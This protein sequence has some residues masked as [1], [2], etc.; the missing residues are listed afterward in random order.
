MTIDILKAKA[1]QFGDQLG[2]FAPASPV[3]SEYVR[4]GQDYL[5]QSGFQNREG[6]SL[7]CRSYHVAGEPRSRL[8]DFEN[9]LVDPEI[10]GLVAARGG[11]GCLQLLPFLDFDLIGRYPK[12][13]LGFSD[14][15]ALQLALWQKLN[16]VT[17]S[18]PMLAVEMARPEI[19]NSALLWGLLTGAEEAEIRSLLSAYLASEKLE[20]LR[21]K[22]FSGR[23]LGGTLTLLASLAGTPYMPDFSGK[24]III[25]DRGESLYRIDRAL[26]QLRLAGVFKSPT[27]VVCGNFSLPN[28]VEEP[29]LSGFLKEFF[30][31]D[32]FPVL[33]NFSYGH[34]PQSFIFPQGGLMEFDC[35]KRIITLKESVVIKSGG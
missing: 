24:I 22:T 26:T 14:L 18:G 34:C 2:I 19:V 35:L 4:K 29:L 15:T 32:E 1:L 3:R 21:S 23:L 5:A 10:K 30:A 9:L 33:I 8:A 31:A 20:C 27:A 7:F 13:I 12:I 17:F 25:E 28:K 11:Y 16:L 6:S